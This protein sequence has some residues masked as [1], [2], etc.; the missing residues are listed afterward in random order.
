MLIRPLDP[1]SSVC[2]PV[3]ISLADG[4]E[5]RLLLVPNLGSKKTWQIRTEAAAYS[6]FTSRSRGL[7]A[8][9]YLVLLQF[10]L[11]RR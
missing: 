1:L 6:L 4:W 5:S 2:C 9:R 3:V 10:L 7:F 8:H 11:L